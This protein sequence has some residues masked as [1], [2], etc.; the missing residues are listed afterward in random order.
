[1]DCQIVT[2]RIPIP[3]HLEAT[4][5]GQAS[6]HVSGLLDHQ[7]QRR[8]QPTAVHTP[9]AR[10]VLDVPDQPAEQ[11]RQPL[12]IVQRRREVQRIQ[13]LI[14]TVQPTNGYTPPGR[15]ARPIAPPN[16]ASDY[17]D[18]PTA[19]RPQSGTPDHDPFVAGERCKWTQP[20]ASDRAGQSMSNLS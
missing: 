6:W 10:L 14:E 2:N 18:P 9:P 15:S 5:G 17:A 12:L 1:M 19:L 13:A 20:R 16:S 7:Q 4:S 3:A 11:R 8:P